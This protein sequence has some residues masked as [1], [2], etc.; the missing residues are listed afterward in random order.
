MEIL[1]AGLLILF[2]FSSSACSS[3]S[4]PLFLLLCLL[5]C[6]T[7]IRLIA[8]RIW[9]FVV[10]VSVGFFQFSVFLFMFY[11]IKNLF[12]FLLFSLFCLLI[13]SMPHFVV[14]FDFVSLLAALAGVEWEQNLKVQLM[15]QRKTEKQ[16]LWKNRALSLFLGEFEEVRNLQIFA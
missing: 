3:P 1:L 12:F 5:I 16:N 13:S 10:V 7:F 15:E 14:D 4:L 8:R 2:L 9:R 11:P 6:F